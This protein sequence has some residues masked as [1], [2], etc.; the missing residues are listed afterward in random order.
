[1]N[2]TEEATKCEGPQLSPST[3]AIPKRP[4]NELME[5]D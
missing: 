2:K 1:M 4:R 3:G 5:L